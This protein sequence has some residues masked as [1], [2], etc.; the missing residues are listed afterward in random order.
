MTATT[1]LPGAEA[2]TLPFSGPGAISASGPRA[3]AAMWSKAGR[4]PTRSCSTALISPRGSISRPMACALFARDVANI[5]MDLKEV[6]HMHFNALGGADN[7]IVGDL[8]GR[9]E[10]H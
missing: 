8:T 10:E 2:M 1:W 4:A 3:T 6:E 5:R 9:S 7:I